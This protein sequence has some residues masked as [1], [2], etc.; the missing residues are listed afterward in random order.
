MIHK[1]M[2]YSRFQTLPDKCSILENTCKKAPP[3]PGVN[4]IYSDY[5]IIIHVI[6]LWII[7]EKCF[8][9]PFKRTGKNK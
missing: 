4:D 6:K 7:L 3:K 2:E 9:L 8:S 5:Y 1:Y